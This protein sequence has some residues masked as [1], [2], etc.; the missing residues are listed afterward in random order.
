M[1]TPFMLQ[2]QST[3]C[4]ASFLRKK[5]HCLKGYKCDFSYNITQ[6][7][8]NLIINKYNDP[9]FTNKLRTLSHLSTVDKLF[10]I[11]PVQQPSFYSWISR[12]VI[13]S[14]GVNSK[15]MHSHRREIVFHC[16]CRPCVWQQIC[17][18]S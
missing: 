18:I 5:G 16:V 9:L 17:A 11:S 12:D 1:I 13:I 4:R 10:S 8:S 14:L 15:S 2:F 7:I 3:W 6:S